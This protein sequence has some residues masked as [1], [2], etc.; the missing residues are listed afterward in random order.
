MTPTVLY[1]GFLFVIT[2]AASLAGTGVMLRY[3]KRHAIL[4]HPNER[5]SHTTPTPHGGGLAVLPVVFT[6]WALSAV[7]AP[8]DIFSG[9]ARNAF[10]PILFCMPLIF[11]SWIDDLKGVSPIIRLLVQAAMVVAFFVF[12]P[13]DVL[14][15]QGLLPPFL[16]ATLAGI[17]W[18]WFINL[19]NFMDG[20]DAITSVET[21]FIGLGVSAVVLIGGGHN[22]LALFGTAIAGAAFG[23]LWWN[24]PPARIFLGDTGSVPLGFLLG[25]LLLSL[26]GRGQW[27]AAVILPLYYLADAT[28]TL[29]KRLIRKRPIWQA[30][31]EHFFQ[32]AVRRGLSH[33]AIVRAIILA[34]VILAL[35]AALSVSNMLSA[36]PWFSFG[37]AILAVGALL[38]YL[39]RR[40]KAP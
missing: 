36:T 11:V 32:M 29:L 6:A 2:T 24:R 13:Q 20:I 1:L 16:D 35:S 4:D 28:I 18:I 17:L 9:F 37:I 39:S 21:V 38:Y 14:Y 40:A 22:D 23:F 27:E 10:L 31:H 34:N 30:H 25:W 3:L 33:G 12:H 26:A 7:I 15:F 8:A 19:F 5:S